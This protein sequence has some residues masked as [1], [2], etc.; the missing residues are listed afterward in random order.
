MITWSEVHWP[1]PLSVAPLIGLLTRLASDQQRGSLVWEA[2]AEAGHI[3]YLIGADTNDLGETS[4][5]LTLFVPGAG[6]APPATSRAETERSGRVRIRQR[7]LSLN[8]GA[9]EQ[10]LQALLGALS[11]TNGKDDVLVIQVILDRALMPEAVPHS[12]EDPTTS[13]FSKLMH[14]PRPATGELRTRLTSKLSEYR[15]RAVVRIGVSA[16]YPARRVAAVHRVLA[17]FRQL[18]SGGTYVDLVPDRPSAVDEARVPMWLPLR[19]TPGEA[20]SFLAWPHGDSELPGMPARHP[21]PLAPPP[22]FVEVRDRAFAVTT[23]PGPARLIGI[24]RNDSFRHTHIVGPT[25]VGKSTVMQHLIK[26]DIAAGISVVLIDPKGDLAT[27]TLAQIPERRWPDVVVIDPTLPQPVGLNPLAESP[28]RRA[29]VTDGILAV[30]RGLFPTAFG[31]RTSDIMHASL[32]TLMASPGATLI[33]LPA[34]LTDAQFR[35]RLTARINDPVGLGPFWEQWEALSP[36]QQAEAIGPVMSRLRQ[37]LLRPGLRA[38]LDQ[39]EPRFQFGEIFSTGRLVIVS[40][41][42]GLI[43]AQSATLLGSLVVSQLWQ[44]AL[45]QAALPEEHRR[46]V[47]VYIDEAQTFLHLDADLG[48]ALEQSRSLRVAWHLAHQYRRQMPA[49]LLAGVDANTRNK[50]VFTLEG[51]DA[52]A[53]ASSSELAP[54]D[55]VRLPPYGIYASLLSEGRQTGWFSGRTLPPPGAISSP[56]T[57]IRESQARYGADPNLARARDVAAPAHIVNVDEESFGRTPRGAT[58]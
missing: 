41:N 3:R 7:S 24:S 48:E 42:K 52:K 20:L 25:G 38:V 54:E 57:I 55:F 11:S 50:I 8:L 4:R 21:R 14:G 39:P 40:L 47:S 19:L 1:R 9:T 6:V 26:A 34:L 51:T 32:L 23:A 10:M 17:A 29:L 22:S 28:E 46:P 15:F 45:A 49:D 58:S 31:P 18:Q 44:L 30:F 36:G 27:D 56:E 35:R 12:I 33:Q 43:G 37:F 53:V 5:L 16:G 2:R 13:I